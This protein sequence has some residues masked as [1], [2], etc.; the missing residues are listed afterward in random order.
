MFPTGHRFSKTESTLPVFELH[1]DD[2]ESDDGKSSHDQSV[3]LEFSDFS[4]ESIGDENERLCSLADRI[5][6]LESHSAR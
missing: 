2:D 1:L 5:D 3:A 6:T 4:R